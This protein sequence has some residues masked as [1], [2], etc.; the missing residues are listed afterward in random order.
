VPAHRVEVIPHGVPGFQFDEETSK[1]EFGLENN[2]V[3]LTFGLIGPNKGVE[4]VLK[5]LQ[6]VVAKYPQIVY[7]V[8][9]KTHPSVL[10]Q[11]GEEYRNYLQ[12]LVKELQLEQHVIFLN[13]FVDEQV[14]SKYLSATDIY[15][16]PYLSKAQITSG[17]LSYAIGAG[18]AV[19]STPYWHAAELLADGR[20]RLFNF[21]GHEQLSSILMGLLDNPGELHELK[22]KARRYGLGTTWAKTGEKYVA[23]ANQY[24]SS[25][26]GNRRKK[27]RVPGCTH[28]PHCYWTM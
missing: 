24:G 4:T 17:T 16:T 20:G 27:K 19:I 15:I 10:R 2:K 26:C 11:T 21:N 28:C 14:L 1:K 18:C 13:E 22:K 3:L 8:L 6:S 7:I 9:G 23:L 25:N 12:Q 5:S